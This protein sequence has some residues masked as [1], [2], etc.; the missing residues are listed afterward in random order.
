MLTQRDAP[1]YSVEVERALVGRMLTHP[2]S[3][4]EVVGRYVERD[5]FHT[6]ECRL[7]F[8]Q[9]ANAHMGGT[10]DPV[11]IGE[12]AR[13]PLSE[14]WSVPE[15]EVSQSLRALARSAASK[16][17][18]AE[19]VVELKSLSARRRIITAAERA[20]EAAR[21]SDDPAQVGMELADIL[22]DIAVGGRRRSQIF[23]RQEA[24]E[25]HIQELRTRVR[26]REAGGELGVLTGYNFFDRKVS[27]IQPGEVVMLAGEPGVGK[28][29][30][31]QTFGRGFARR[32]LRRAD[33]H[34]IGTLVINL[35]MTRY[36][37]MNRDAQMLTGIDGNRLRKAEVG[38]ADFQQLAQAY[39]KDD[40][41]V[42]PLFSNYASRL[43]ASGLRAVIIDA[44]NRGHN[45][46]F[47]IIDHFRMWDLDKGM[48]GK[49]AGSN[50]IDEEK[51]RFLKE[52]AKD[53]N[54]A[55]LCLAHTV[56]MD[57]QGDGRPR[58]SDL[59]GSYQVA[60]YCDVVAF[61]Y[62]PFMYASPT[63]REHGLVKETMAEMIFAKNRNGRRGDEMFHFD[64][65]RM[66]VRDI[67]DNQLL[68]P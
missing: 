68:I 2:E 39:I 23:T 4:P 25:A 65:E 61:V 53:L 66:E 5:D 41:K 30:V 27:G 63:E 21:T 15:H 58:M 37:D 36:V 47:V 1:P 20:M 22:T 51:A 3:V 49:D 9:I 14:I 62:Q 7:L 44:L 18:V 6:A 32:Q 43:N 50:Q 34:R 24:V 26:I 67:E 55:I 8:E 28:S 40:Y 57:P 54:I 48:V 10:V 12:R 38:P 17:A 11:V 13:K 19:Y 31:A 45:T 56:K 33:E 46:G 64:G 35:E 16:S 52:L 60:A 42:L 59:R 29:A